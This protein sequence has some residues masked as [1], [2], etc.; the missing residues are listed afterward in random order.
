MMNW[1]A[2]GLMIA[3]A[4]PAAFAPRVARAQSCPTCTPD[5]SPRRFHIA[6]ALGL[7]A[8][9]PQKASVALGVLVGE[10]WRQDSRDHARNIAVFAEPGLSAGRASIAY[11]DHGYGSF[12]SGFGIA[13][14]VMRTWKDPWTVADNMTYA[15]GEVILWPIVF[16][17][18]RIGFFRSIAGTATT[19]KW[20]ISLDVGIGL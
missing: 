8:G 20:F 4:G 9:T 13:G 7:H 17:G 14:T 18:P 19:K 12:G 11:V 16:I 6:P 5:N 1:K 10:E 3:V 2:A 15:G